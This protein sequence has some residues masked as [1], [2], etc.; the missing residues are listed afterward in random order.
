MAASSTIFRPSQSLHAFTDDALGTADATGLAEQ[1][2]RGEVSATELT[3]ATV[4]RARSVDP[5]FGA[6]QRGL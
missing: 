3:Q 1:L 4:A 6:L 5:G 2:K